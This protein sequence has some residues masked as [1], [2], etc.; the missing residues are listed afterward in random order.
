MDVDSRL[1]R[2][3]M[4]LTRGAAAG[5]KLDAEWV[6]G[7][8]DSSSTRDDGGGGGGGVL[9]VGATATAT[10]ASTGKPR[11]TRTPVWKWMLCALVLLC[12]CGLSVLSSKA[13]ETRQENIEDVRRR[14]G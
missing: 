11:S 5:Q 7:E 9:V 2:K 3:L 8:K 6:G 12:C 4:G 13:E 14:G 10:T 1:C